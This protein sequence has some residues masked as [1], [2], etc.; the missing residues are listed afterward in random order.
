[1]SISETLNLIRWDMRINRGASWDSIR[2]KL[3]LIEL[4]MEQ[5][6]YGRLHKNPSRIKHLIW[7]LIRGIG[8][9]LQWFF[10][11][12]NIPGTVP[13]GPGLRL[14][15]PQNII[16][17]GWADIGAFC[18]IYQN[19]TIALN[20]FQP[21]TTGFPK[22]GD[23]VLVGAN[24]IVLGNVIIGSDVLIGAGTVVSMDVPDQS[25]VTGGRA[26]V[27]ERRRSD[28]TA[29][30]GSERHLQDPYAIWR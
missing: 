4:R 24:A 25:R 15:H 8:S 13:I 30:P 10:C 21:T 17:T 18:T 20:G 16:V 9:L 19:S 12:S 27:V 2:A 29:V 28:E 14:P 6:W 1:M 26:Q 7:L 11:N 23:R 5:Y 3:F 22:L